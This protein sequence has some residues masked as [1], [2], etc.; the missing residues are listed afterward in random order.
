VYTCLLGLALLAACQ[1]SQAGGKLEGETIT[2]AKLGNTATLVVPSLAQNFTEAL[3][4]KFLQQTRLKLTDREGDLQFSGNITR[5]EVVPLTIQAGDQASQNRM[6]LT[7]HIRF[8]HRLAPEQSWE[9]DFTNFIDFPAEQNAQA[10][11]L[12]LPELVN[13]LVQ[14]I[15]TK[16]LSNW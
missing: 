15:F 9:Q 7:V 10:E 8:T 13:K 5:Y 1:Y 11:T 3:R 16:T 6:N 12:Y 2:V 14:D 4:D